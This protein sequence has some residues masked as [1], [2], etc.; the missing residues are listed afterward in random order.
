MKT[1]ALVF[2]L[3]L[4]NP[5]L[6]SAES[7]PG[8]LESVCAA[9]SNGALREAEALIYAHPEILDQGCFSE[10]FLIQEAR[11][12]NKDFVDFALKHNANVLVR[13]PG[14]Q[15]VLHTLIGDKDHKN[16]AM[17]RRLPLT[18]ATVN[19]K[20]TWGLTPLQYALA[21]PVDSEEI[22]ELLLKNGAETDVKGLSGYTPLA[23]AVAQGS[24][25]K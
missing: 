10:P 15:T 1:T 4:P 21:S 3:L 12:G 18:T 13:G 9:L 11:T 23:E 19:A 8:P 6:S 25:K 5:A 2:A 14:G 24:R 22:M 7:K 17:L 16:L 20:D